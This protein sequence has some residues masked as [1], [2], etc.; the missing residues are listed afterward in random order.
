M[1]DCAQPIFFFFETS[2]PHPS[3]STVANHTTMCIGILATYTFETQF[4]IR[5]CDSSKLVC[6]SQDSLDVQGCLWPHVNINIVY[7]HFC[8]FFL[9]GV[10]LCHQAKVQPPPPRFKRF[11]C[12]SLLSSWDYR[13]PPPRPNNF[14]I[15]SRDGVLPRW[16]GWS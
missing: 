7:L 12:L 9:D 2:H 16:P 15:F 13:R 14:C 1:S 8:F 6:I 10:L 5:N 11:P 3:W 4:D